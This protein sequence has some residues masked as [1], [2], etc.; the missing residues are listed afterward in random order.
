MGTFIV[1]N[2][3]FLDDEEAYAEFERTVAEEGMEAF[4]DQGNVVPIRG[5]LACRVAFSLTKCCTEY[6]ERQGGL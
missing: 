2:E 1:W 3:T 5:R 4:L 6:A